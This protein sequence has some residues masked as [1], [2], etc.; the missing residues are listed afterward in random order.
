LE[1]LTPDDAAK[2]C[3][4]TSVTSY[5]PTPRSSPEEQRRQTRREGSLKYTPQMCT[6]LNSAYSGQA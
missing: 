6:T 2:S 3:P 4:R 1:G 5:Q